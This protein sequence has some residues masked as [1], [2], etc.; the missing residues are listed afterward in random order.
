M[1]YPKTQGKKKKK[2]TYGQYPT[3]KGWD[4]L[5]V[6]EIEWELCKSYGSP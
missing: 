6:R 1:M 4:L 3:G 5:S 2:E